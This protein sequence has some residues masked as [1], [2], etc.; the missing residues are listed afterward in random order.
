MRSIRAVRKARWRVPGNS[1]QLR[2]VTSCSISSAGMR[3]PSGALGLIFGNQQAGDI[4]AVAGAFL[5]SVARRHPVAVAVEQHS[6]EQGRLASSGA[7]VALGDVDRKLRLNR[8]PERLIDYW[9]VFAGM[10]LSLVNDFAAVNAVL[11][12]Q[13]ERTARE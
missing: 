3:S 8:T 1:G 13:I 12:H 6:G 11:Q 5:D 7:R 9:H 4:V 2:L 10:G